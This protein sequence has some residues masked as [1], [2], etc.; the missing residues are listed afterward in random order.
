VSFPSRAEALVVLQEHT[1][2]ESLLKHA[3]A[4][5]AAMRFYASHFGEDPERWGAAGLLH[6]FDYE[7]Y[8]S[9]D[10][11]PFKGAEI[12]RAR[13]YDADLIDTILSHADHTGV[14]RTTPMQKALFAVD[15]LCGF[16]TAV[17]LVRPSKKIDEVEPSSVKK[18]LKDKA[19]ARNVSRE[20]IA[21]GAEL[22]DIPLDAHIQ[23]VITALR[24]IASELGL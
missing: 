9:L 12:L 16:V 3:Y 20:D 4:V 19:F 17:T 21:K 23:N 10:D 14:P 13:G 11:H 22:I 15:E 1:R 7:Q 8:P 2:G 24:G 18:K 5:E 6:D